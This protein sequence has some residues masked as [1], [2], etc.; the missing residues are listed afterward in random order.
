MY[1]LKRIANKS[2]SR[3]KKYVH[4]EQNT[5]TFYSGKISFPN[6]TVDRKQEF[7]DRQGEWARTIQ[8]ARAPDRVMQT[9]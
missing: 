8:N 3:T 2:Y 6:W 5:F 1:S 9:T 7:Y 4:S